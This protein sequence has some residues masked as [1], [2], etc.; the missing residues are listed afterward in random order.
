VSGA[1]AS[2]MLIDGMELARSPIEKQ[3]ITAE[4]KIPKKD[5]SLPF[6]D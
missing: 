2:S 1:K 6:W 4:L 3:I 5:R